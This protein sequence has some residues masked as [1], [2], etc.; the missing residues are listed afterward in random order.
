MLLLFA[1]SIVLAQSP[2]DLQCATPDAISALQGRQP[3]SWPTMLDAPVGVGNAHRPPPPDGHK[4]PYGQPTGLF[5][6][7]ENFL[8]S[9][10]DGSLSLDSI[11]RTADALEGAWTQLVEIQGWPAPVSSERYLIWVIFDPDL[12]GTGFTT[13]YFDEVYPQGY[14]VIFV[15]PTNIELEAFWASLMVHEFM[16]TVHFTMRDYRFDL[17]EETWYWEASATHASELAAPDVDG[18]Q[19]ISAA[20]AEFPEARYDTRE[21]AHDY[22]MFVLNAWLEDPDLGVGPGTMHAIWRAGAERPDALWDELIADVTR[23]DAVTVWAAF[24]ADYGNQQMPESSQYTPARLKG[25][26]SEQGD[27]RLPY[28]GTDYWE[29]EADGRMMATGDVRVSTP[30]GVFLPQTTAAV[31]RGDIIAVTAAVDGADYTLVHLEEDARDLSQDTGDAAAR[32]TPESTMT[33][34]CADRG[35]QM[36]SGVLVWMVLLW[37]RRPRQVHAEE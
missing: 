33:R 32:R 12:S 19:Y 18:H 13:E 3:A 30:D 2:P 23:R 24:A 21:R 4:V 20:Y 27:G 29:I 16:H 36:G 6:E 9:W 1:G 26:L 5:L 35:T 15:N 7:T 28:L 10:E 31:Q 22:G 34:G 8:I 37:R 11:D 25:T 17:T 14:P